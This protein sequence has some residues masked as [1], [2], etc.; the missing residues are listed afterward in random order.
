[1][2]SHIEIGVGYLTKSDF[3]GVLNT[4]KRTDRMRTT[5]LAFLFTVIPVTTIVS[6]DFTNDQIAFF[7]SRVRPVF[8]EAC[9]KCHARGEQS[10]GGL[11][12]SSR[13][14][15]LRG[16]DSGPILV[17]GDAEASPLLA[18][19]RHDEDALAEMPPD[20]RLTDQQ[21]DDIAAWIEMGAPWSETTLVEESQAD[22]LWALEPVAN[23]EVPAVQNHDWPRN[24]ID[25]FVLARL[26]EAG[27]QPAQPAA[28]AVLLRRVTYDLTGLPPTPEEVEAF[29]ADES[30]DAFEEAVERLLA[31]PHYGE[32]WGRHW[33]DLMRY[34]D[35]NGF[36]NDYGKPNAFR[37]R[38]Y[39]I[40]AFN[41][42]VPYD[43]FIREH[44]AGD[45][46]ESP[47]V[48]RDG[49]QAMSPVATAF[50]WLGE[51]LNAPADRDRAMA[52]EVENRIDVLGKAFLGLTLACARCHDHKTDPI[53]SEDYYA[54]AGFFNSS[55][56]VQ[57][58]IDTESRRA[59]IAET[60]EQIRSKYQ[61]IDELLHRPEVLLKRIDARLENASEISAYLQAA[62]EVL[63]EGEDRGNEE[64]A[65]VAR[66]HQLDA[67]RLQKWTAI[68]DRIEAD[69]AQIVHYMGEF[70]YG[71]AGY[72][73][74]PIFVPWFELFASTEEQLER[75]LPLL[76]NRL[77]GRN[78]AMA[79]IMAQD[80]LFEDFD[81]PEFTSWEAAGWTVE[82]EAFGSGPTECS[83]RALQ[84]GRGERMISSFRGSNA[85]TGRL[86]SPK[87]V[88]EKPYL[89]F[90]AAGGNYLNRTG[91]HLIANSQILPEPVDL[92]ATG[93]GSNLFQR[94]VFNMRPY[95]GSEVQLEIV[96]EEVG[97]WGFIV[98][99]EISFMEEG[100]SDFQWV[101]VN[102]RILD[103]LEAGQPVSGALGDAY[104][105]AFIETLTSWR[106]RVS[107]GLNDGIDQSPSPVFEDADR[108]QL[109]NWAMMDDG[110]LAPQQ[111][112]ASVLP[113]ELGSQLT[114][115]YADLAELEASGPASKLAPVSLDVEPV[116]VHL[117]FQ[118]D[119]ANLGDE[120]PRRFPHSLS[121]SSERPELQGSGR[122]ELGEWIAR[123]DHPL[124]SRVMVNRIWLHHFGESLVPT[125][126]NFGVSGELPTH[127]ELLDYLAQ[128]F[129][130]SGWS[131][132]DMHRLMLLSSTYRQSSEVNAEALQIDPKNVLLHHY[133]VRRL[134]AE[135]VRDGLLAVAGNADLHLYGPA[136]P[137]YISP[138]MEGEDLPAISG[139]LD[140]ERRRSIYLEV[141]RNHLMNLLS[142]FDFP[143]PYTTSGDRRESVLPSQALVLLNNE[144]VAQ[145]AGV[146]ADNILTHQASNSDRVEEAY[147][148]AFS[149]RP[150]EQETTKAVD[151]LDQQRNRYTSDG[152]T[153]GEAEAQSWQDL[154]HVLFNLSEFIFIR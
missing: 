119:P 87:F 39:V 117:Q 65:K 77:R 79:D 125:P 137:T 108:E 35:T 138:Y 1:M 60:A 114:R 63:S 69:F 62:A 34:A 111:G 10:K 42:D 75:Q 54:L 30:E 116:N 85:F 93:A 94:K 68:Y 139:P 136:V 24:Q 130:D 51:M 50:P 71:Q 18:I 46:M 55:T 38:D 96:D 149:R 43:Q 135:C 31:S 102:T 152:V 98:V 115:L 126:D 127:P 58:C 7:E 123:A 104:Q 25:R 67:K 70:G 84:H 83:I 153:P 144:L 131:I 145:Q 118:G 74:T 97:P 107:Q 121:S 17:P 154:C 5:I 106:E 141:R 8:V 151:F 15:L 49:Q 76:C 11:Q 23:V 103:E 120:V 91:V 80:M 146:W 32:R 148:R 78:Q 128:R 13:E 41:C 113:A 59:T 100:P 64:I 16:G 66:A 90:I 99:D 132:K 28:R 129:V 20:D 53:T 26:E 140:G 122:R 2:G 147:L 88:A 124:T 9:G 52:E 89:T 21:I 45:L 29:L 105:A 142:V 110:P 44:F 82:G 48:S 133:P 86:V 4:T 109:R 101:P 57:R 27:L 73:E 72:E 33:L 3:A 12:L 95:L 143:K 56:N 36:D 112:E 150:S 134:E 40:E 47:R 22:S 37:Y 81:R 19:L 14:L 61:Q 92:M 6:E